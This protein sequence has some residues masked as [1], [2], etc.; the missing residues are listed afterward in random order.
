M[1]YEF[2][3]TYPRANR[4]AHESE[5]EMNDEPCMILEALTKAGWVCLEATRATENS[6]QSQLE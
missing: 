3:E 5:Y 4:Q 2:S 1:E 6:G